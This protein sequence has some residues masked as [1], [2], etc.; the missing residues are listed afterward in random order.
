DAAAVAEIESAISDAK[1]ALGGEDVDAMNKAHDR[2]M[3]SS[4]KLA[5]VLYTSTAG[6]AGQASSAAAG[7]DGASAASSDENVIDAEYVDV[8]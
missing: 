3:Q 1:S 5:E 2:L 6:S 8:E 4:H 7:S